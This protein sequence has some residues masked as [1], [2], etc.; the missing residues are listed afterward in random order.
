MVEPASSFD[1]KH[2]EFRYRHLRLLAAMGA[3]NGFVSAPVFFLLDFKLLA[4]CCL[5]YGVFCLMTRWLAERQRHLVGPLCHL[6]IFATLLLTSSGPFFQTADLML[7]HWV[8]TVPVI[9]Y[10]FCRRRQALLWVGITMLWEIGV[11]LL[12]PQTFSWESVLMV[13]AALAASATALHAFA[14]YLEGNEQLIVMLSNTDSLTNTL[15]RRSFPSVLEAEARRAWRQHSA[16]TVFMVDVDFFKQYNDRY[17]HVR[18]DDILVSVAQALK[19]AA[20]RS[21]D[22]VF[23]YGGEEF[24]LICGGL[25]AEQALTFAERMRADVAAL[26]L[27]HAGS[28]FGVVTVSIGCHRADPRDPV[29]PQELVEAADRA[30]YVAKLRGRNRVELSEEDEARASVNAA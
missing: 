17:G 24:C 8:M 21:G 22:H 1:E 12:T 20:Q 15:N 14:I 5:S 18:G 2:A 26:A 11:H 9:A 16:L 25:D 28:L 30:L 23:R 13:C 19:H 6:G 27:P 10:I 4:S 7:V 29:E 3:M